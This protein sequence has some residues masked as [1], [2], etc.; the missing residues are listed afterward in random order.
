MSDPYDES[1]S[2]EGAATEEPQP[3]Q[4]FQ[5]VT[6]LLSCEA[7]QP[8]LSGS[9]VVSRHHGKVD[10]AMGAT[11]SCSLQAWLDDGQGNCSQT[12]VQSGT[13]SPGA[14]F[15]A[16]IDTSLSVAN[17]PSGTIL[18]VT[19]VSVVQDGQTTLRDEKQSIIQIP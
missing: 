7:G 2:G 13:A 5:P 9:N 15:A 12:M 1:G 14:P 6:N 11:V 4:T 19:A 3:A 10:A 17:H 8:A 16:T 18:R